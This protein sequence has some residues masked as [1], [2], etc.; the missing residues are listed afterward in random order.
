[1]DPELW[2]GQNSAPG[3]AGPPQWFALVT[4]WTFK[5]GEEM[6]FLLEI[7]FY[8]YI[9]FYNFILEIT[10]GFFFLNVF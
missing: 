5:A 6:F 7:N 2:E 4:S 10:V 3:R 9:N 8:I 1:M